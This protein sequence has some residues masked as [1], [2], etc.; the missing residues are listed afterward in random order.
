MISQ[1]QIDDLSARLVAEWDARIEKRYFRKVNEAFYENYFMARFTFY[2]HDK[3]DPE[4]GAIIH[5]AGDVMR[6]KKPLVDPKYSYTDKEGG[7]HVLRKKYWKWK[8]GTIH[9]KT[10][11][12][13]PPKAKPM[14]DAMKEIESLKSKASIQQTFTK[15][16]KVPN[17]AVVT[18]GVTE[19]QAKQVDYDKSKPNEIGFFGEVYD[20]LPG[21]LRWRDDTRFGDHKSQSSVDK[22]VRGVLREWLSDNGYTYRMT[23][24]IE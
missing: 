4:T 7:R 1:N 16:T 10:G 22:F 21:Y 19:A 14:R 17:G 23:T 12:L 15:R 13:L 5:R 6:I 2:K 24:E 18:L 9:S 3:K 11:A 8:G 20:D